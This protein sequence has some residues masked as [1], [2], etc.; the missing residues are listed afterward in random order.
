MNDAC[1][2]GVGLVVLEPP[3]KQ[4]GR[5]LN[6]DVKAD[7]ER[8][9]DGDPRE[10]P[11]ESEAPARGCFSVGRDP[12]LVLKCALTCELLITHP[13][14]APPRPATDHAVIKRP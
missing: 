12:V 13:M 3:S 10:H 6:G 4:R 8:Y 2:N 11:A 9:A 7:K 5:F 14:L 1:M